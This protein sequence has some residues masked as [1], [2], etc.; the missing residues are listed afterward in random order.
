MFCNII[1]EFHFSDVKSVSS[2][3][4]GT[5]LRAASPVMDE[6]SL[7]SGKNAFQ[8]FTLKMVEQYMKEEAVR[9]QHRQALL[10]LQERALLDKTKAEIAWIK[11][12]RR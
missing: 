5:S 11:L 3:G 7:F 4:Q 9:A 6:S 12:Q 1:D 8:E 2:E 10:Q